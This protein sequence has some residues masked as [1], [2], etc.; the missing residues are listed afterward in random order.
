VV[1]TSPPRHPF[2][3][4]PGPIPFA[5]RGGAT[6]A[7]EN[8]MP[9]FERAVGLGY[10]YLETDVHTTADG[11]VVAFHDDDLSRTCGRPG[12]ISELPWREVATCRVDGKEPIPGSSISSTPGRTPG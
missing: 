9:A 7:P 12:R 11:I 10:H 8:T 5:H 4:W 6:E 2:L 3:D 1:R